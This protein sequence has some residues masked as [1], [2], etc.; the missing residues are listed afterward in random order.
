MTGS[1]IE[2]QDD[3]NHMAYWLSN[4]SMLLFLLQRTLKGSGANPNLPPP[5]TSFFGRMAKVPPI[6]AQKLFIQ[7]FSYINVQLFNSFLLRRECCTFSNGKYVKA[8]L[9]ELE[10]WCGHAK[11][12]VLF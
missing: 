6:L 7:I 2:N 1:A 12:E 10:L 5:P 9:A 3:S 8:E 4:T 11:E